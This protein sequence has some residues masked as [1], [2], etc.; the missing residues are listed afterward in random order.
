MTAY[1]LKKCDKCGGNIV[2]VEHEE[3]PKEPI[4]FEVD[5]GKPCECKESRPMNRVDELWDIFVEKQGCKPTK[6]DCSFKKCNNWAKC[7]ILIDALADSEA[8]RVK[9]MFPYL[10]HHQN[11]ASLFDALTVGISDKESICSCGLQ[12]IKK[13]VEG[14]HE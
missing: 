11:C 5:I 10:Q 12:A 9:L 4:I 1:S 3:E 8:E 6:E 2:V 13:V 14:S 7:Q